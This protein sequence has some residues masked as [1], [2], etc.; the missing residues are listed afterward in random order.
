MLVE[1]VPAYFGADFMFI[2]SES[3]LRTGAQVNFGVGT[4][5]AEYHVEWGNTYPI[6]CTKFN[7]FD[8]ARDAYRAILRWSES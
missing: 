8:V 4:P 7:I 1:G 2:P 3:K 5:G 6:E